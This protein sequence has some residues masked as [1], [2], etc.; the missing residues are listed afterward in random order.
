VCEILLRWKCQG[1]AHGLLMVHVNAAGSKHRLSMTAPPSREASRSVTPA[2]SRQPTPS[3]SERGAPQVPAEGVDSVLEQTIGF[4]YAARRAGIRRC[5]AS[6]AWR[7]VVSGAHT[8]TTGSLA[9]LPQTL[10]LLQ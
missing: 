6:S 9:Y 4:R 10:P 8:R 5:G 3:G 2:A 1:F 7:T